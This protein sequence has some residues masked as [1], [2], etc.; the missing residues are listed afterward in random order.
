MHRANGPAG[1]LVLDIG[2]TKIA[3]ALV[4][5]GGQIRLARAVPS[6]AQDGSE[7]VLGRAIALAQAIQKE[8]LDAGWPAPRAAGVGSA[9]DIDPGTG[10]VRFATTAIPGW[11][12]LPLRE[13]IAAALSLPTF[14]DNDGNVMALGETLHGAGRGSRH[15]IGL[16]VGTG[17]GGGL[18]LNGRIYHGADGIAGAVG[19]II[20]ECRE[21][22]PC[23]CGGSGCLEAYASGP[24]IAGDFLRR[25][26][27]D[28][29]AQLGLAPERLGVRELAGLA[30]QGHPAAQAAIRQ[31]AAYLGAG[32]A[33]LLNL[34]NPQVVVI[35][36]GVAQIGES[37][38]AEVR[39]AA[40]G[41]AKRSVAGAAILPAALGTDANLVGAAEFAWQSL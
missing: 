41:R 9:G 21:P 1:V 34:L 6:G 16:T 40:Q 30:R 23:A 14:V 37:Y 10:R 15:V 18:I 24:A 11:T 3:G 7:A 36:G 29:P 13:R 39:R 17:I 25:L 32:I 5:P 20:V 33:S 26:G 19:H 4:A 12:G 8:A 31:G 35:G 38:L 2:G 27:A 22:R 28:E